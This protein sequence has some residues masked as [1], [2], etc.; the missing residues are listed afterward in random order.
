MKLNG[1]LELTD[2]G[3]ANA[4]NNS[5][6]REGSVF[7]KKLDNTVS[8]LSSTS[9]AIVLTGQ[10]I[11]V[12]V[13]TGSLVYYDS[14][15]GSWYP[16]DG[17]D[18][19]T[20]VKTAASDITLF[21][22]ADV[23]NGLTAGLIYNQ[24]VVSGDSLTAGGIG[25]KIGQAISTSTLLVDIDTESSGSSSI[26]PFAFSYISTNYSG[27][28]IAYWDC[29][30]NGAFTDNTG[31]SHTGTISGA[32]FTA[33]GKLGGAYDYN[34]TSDE[35]TIAKSYDFT[36]LG[37]TIID[38]FDRSDSATLGTASNGSTWAETEDDA[39]ATIQIVSNTVKWASTNVTGLTSARLNV[40][41]LTAWDIKYKFKYTNSAGGAFFNFWLNNSDSHAT[42]NGT[43][44]AL[45]T[46]GSYIELYDSAGGQLT[47]TIGALSQSTDYYVRWKYAGTTMYLK[48]W[49]ASVDEPDTW[50]ITGTTSNIGTNS[51]LKLSSGNAATA[52]V[53]IYGIDDILNGTDEP[54]SISMWMYR[55]S[56]GTADTLIAKQN[57]SFNE[58]YFV[59]FSA[60]GTTLN[61]RLCTSVGN[62]SEKLSVVSVST[63]A[64]HHIVITY[65]GSEDISGVKIYVDGALD[66]GATNSGTGFT[67]FKNTIEALRIGSRR[68]SNSSN[69]WFDG[70]L[71]EIGVWNGRVLNSTEVADIYNAGNGIPYD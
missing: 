63:G 52:T 10:P 45:S 5:I 21:G 26:T 39:G 67:G 7:Y 30:T 11:D 55:D 54:F 48:V 59:Y 51:Y 37:S 41:T 42:N 22:K 3:S 58:E 20:G 35:V 29:D 4:P 15:I 24:N 27:S 18:T 23:Y 69:N 38:N 61:V 8:K 53:E 62:N 19:P 50:N 28:L 40:G 16:C 17:D 68:V 31:S 12:T 44:V 47:P 33:S 9:E 56:S 60:G 66:T 49:L 57:Q 13:G 6:F 36:F 25:T 65:D 43:R 70:K 71:D 64:W 46:A 1:Y 32:T 14:G 2:S 34:G